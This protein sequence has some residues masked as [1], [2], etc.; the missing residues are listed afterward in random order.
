MSSA[1]GRYTA[2]ENYTDD[3]LVKMALARHDDPLLS[4]IAQRFEEFVE[5][6]EDADADA[7]E[8]REEPEEFDSHLIDSRKDTY[9]ILDELAN[10]HGVTSRSEFD[11]FMDERKAALDL[12]DEFDAYVLVDRKTTFRLL[13]AILEE[14]ID[15][16]E[17]LTARLQN[18]KP[19]DTDM[20]LEQALIDNTA[21]T[22]ELIAILKGGV[23]PAAPANDQGDAPEK[24]QPKPE[25]AKPAAAKAEKP[26]TEEPAAVDRDALSKKLVAF[27]KEKGREE[28]LALLAKFDAKNLN[29]VPDDKLPAFEAELS[30]AAA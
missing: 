2:H 30:K 4:E 13:H 14:G 29:S 11:R 28:A 15:N 5:T 26:K 16:A 3:E 17:A 20:S 8:M 9:E 10:Y 6:E 27:G 18:P 22:R 21:A 7:E 23:L 19:G 1:P 24:P 12:V 25:K